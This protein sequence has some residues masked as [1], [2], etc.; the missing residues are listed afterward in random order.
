MDFDDMIWLNE[1][2]MQRLEQEE[3]LGR[4]VTVEEWFSII[5]PGHFPDEEERRVFYEWNTSP[6]ED[7][8]RSLTPGTPECREWVLDYV[9]LARLL[10]LQH[11]QKKRG[12]R[13]TRWYDGLPWMP[14][15]VPLVWAE[16]FFRMIFGSSA[17]EL[18]LESAD[19]DYRAIAEGLAD[20]F[21]FDASEIVREV[22]ERAKDKS[23]DIKI[24]DR[25]A[26]AAAAPLR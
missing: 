1:K 24:D 9:G 13:R 7:K 20:D 10:Q 14:W 25:Q 4:R 11:L 26:D 17:K 2:A 23:R 18:P 19:T 22:D 15:G 3:D 6:T 21:G 5:S 16:W 8:E 12:Y